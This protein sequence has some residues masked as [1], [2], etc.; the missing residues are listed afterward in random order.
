MKRLCCIKKIT[1]KFNNI[2]ICVKDYGGHNTPGKNLEG[3]V[4]TANGVEL[5]GVLL[6]PI[7]EQCNGC[8]RIRT[9]EGQEFCSSYAI[10]SKKWT[11]GRCN[12]ATHIKV[13]VVAKAKVNPLKASKR[14]A[15]GR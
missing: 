7:T 4:K 14:A 3:A 13:E 10:P 2:E 15:K 8:D 9:F 11:L 5:N 1:T 6:Q 12:F